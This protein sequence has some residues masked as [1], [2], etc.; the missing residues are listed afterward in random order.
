MLGKDWLFE[1]SEETTISIYEQA[2]SQGL[3]NPVCLDSGK[4]TLNCL[5]PACAPE[6]TVAA[7]EPPASNEIALENATADWK[8]Y[9]ERAGVETPLCGSKN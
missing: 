7:A 9:G 4:D 6:A 8:V 1:V 2:S 3:C 5:S